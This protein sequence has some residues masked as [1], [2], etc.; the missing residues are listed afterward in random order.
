M[1][2]SIVFKEILKSKVTL[3]G[4]D[5][6]AR[7]KALDALLLADPA[8]ISDFR[9]AIV[10][11]QD[12]WKK[13]PGLADAV[14]EDNDNFL[15]DGPTI[16]EIYQLAAEQRVSLGL[17]AVT[18]EI[19]VKILTNNQEECRA[20]LASRPELGTLNKVP[21]WQPDNV[22][23]ATIQPPP[24]PANS[25]TNVL[26][27]DAITA[28]QKQAAELFL[29]RLITSSEEQNVLT[30]LLNA[31]NKT[32]M[33]AAAKKLGFPASGNAS[34]VFPL[35]TTQRKTLDD[36]IQF[37]IQDAARN[38]F[39][40]Y[41]DSL[42]LDDVL[43]QDGLLQE[44]DPAIFK[45]GLPKPFDTDLADEDINWAKS[46][47]GV[48]YLTDVLPEHA[49]VT[50]QVMNAKDTAALKTEL[51]TLLDPHDYIDQ[52]VTDEHL[53]AIKK[54]MLRGYMK[55]N[56]NDSQL[57]ALDDTADLDK[58]VDV[59]TQIGINPADWVK[60]GDLKEVKQ[61]A[62]AQ[63]FAMKVS[64]ASQMGIESHQALLT[65]FDKLP[66]QKQREVLSEPQYMQRLLQ[67]KDAETVEY[68]L[69][70]SSA[71]IS[72]FLAENQKNSGFKAIHNSEVARILA[73]FEPEIE[74]NEAQ[75]AA[76]NEALAKA[77][78]TPNTFT[79][80]ALYKVL[81][82][83]IRA[84]CGSVDETLFNQAFNLNAAR[85]DFTDSTAVRDAIAQQDAM[86]ID[87]FAAYGLPEHARHTRLLDVFLSLDKNFRISKDGFKSIQK[88]F[89]QSSSV[90]EFINTLIPEPQPPATDLAPEYRALK[91]RL[92]NEFSSALFNAI[93]HGILK[94]QFK[95][96]SPDEVNEAINK[97]QKDLAAMQLMHKHIIRNVS[98]FKPIEEVEP[99]H[100][101]NPTFHGTAQLHAQEMKEKYEEFS[102]NCDVIVDQLRRDKITLES[103]LENIPKLAD[104]APGLPLPERK[105]I[106]I[107]RKNIIIELAAVNKNLDFYEKVQNKLSGDKG[108]LQAIDETIDGKK[109]YVFKAEGVTRRFCKPGEINALPKAGSVLPPNNGVRTNGH[110]GE[111]QKF[112]LGEVIPPEHIAVFDVVKTSYSSNGTREFESRGRFS[113]DPS[114][115]ALVSSK[116]D[117]V[118][119]IPGGTFEIIEFPK[120]TVPPATPGS[121]KDA[122]LTKAKMEFSL[123]MAAEILASMDG[124]PTKAKPLMLY[125]AN[126]EEMGYLWTALI[127]L[128][129]KDPKMKFGPEAIK[130]DK[131][132]DNK[133][134]PD[135]Q[136]GL[137]GFN[138][139][140]LY[141]KFKKEEQT[142]VD[143]KVDALGEVTKDKFGK[144][145][146]KERIDAKVIKANESLKEG[147]NEVR[148]NARRATAEQG[149]VVR[150]PKPPG[151]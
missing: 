3:S 80:A 117:K 102:E 2:K 120:Q 77:N 125:G 14:Y 76:I 98:H 75:I 86:N 42:S 149:P 114:P 91:S 62:R 61:W 139:D 15:K 21:D 54:A 71:G 97:V 116:G 131:Y 29:S 37:L 39:E 112:L 40:S 88:A 92:T 132:G 55:R 28:I 31:K 65:V 105:K 87:L 147:L 106:E 12:F 82:D 150:S 78:A 127:I 95:A 81:I 111:T 128:G 69:G 110:S 73:H 99:Y 27:N 57:K 145:D 118:T 5:A 119:K 1:P 48:R 59:L 143:R 20:Y 53:G 122:R 19:L 64:Q 96:V 45:A 126:A 58:F 133:F 9:K 108:I 4:A 17:Q 104:L 11:H 63:W 141:K 70:K 50:L 36:R 60:N 130:L 8:K 32:A 38:G 124:P 10:V 84:Q 142:L 109:S 49:G 121:D 43:K 35:N 56:L 18:D 23:V 144:K 85:T 51:K 100:L 135:T 7:N 66:V 67:A 47:L 46:V 30:D 137:W 148:N 93:K 72:D 79:D 68:Y 13:L 123:T 24:P 74:L 34:L 90:T 25:H 22:P 33:E 146:E 129:E 41:V 52:T 136:R 26:T 16:K 107:L 103:Y 134:D 113:H 89:D 138:K 44:A 83:D 115:P 94:E 151:V 101:Y 6:A 140:S